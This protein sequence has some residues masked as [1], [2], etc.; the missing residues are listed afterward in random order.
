MMERSIIYSYREPDLTRAQNILYLVFAF[1]YGYVLQALPVLEFMD[2]ENYLGHASYPLVILGASAARGLVVLFANEPLWFLI[3]AGLAR[4][5]EPELILRAVIFFGGF[6]LSLSL[7]RA[8]PKYGF[9]LMAFMLTPQIIKNHITHLRQ[10]LAMA[11]FFAGFFSKGQIRRWALMAA[12]PFIHASFFFVLPIV[13][14]PSVIKYMR[15][16]VDIRLLAVGGFAVAASYSLG[17]VATILGARQATRYDFDF[18]N[19]SGLG[20]AFWL[21][22]GVLFVLQ[23]KTFLK[24]NQDAAGLLIVYLISYFFVD[25]AAR[26]FESGLPFILLAGLSLASWRRWTFISAYLLYSTVQWILR[27][28]SPMPF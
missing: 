27:L 2:R 10:G 24:D 3:N 14:I 8:N 19:V 22:I 23:G 15:F 6:F 5:L 16:A 18:V 21:A 28:S 9:W 4:F 7:L 26:I 25:V 17:I 1:G 11:V 13:I 20:F 12:A